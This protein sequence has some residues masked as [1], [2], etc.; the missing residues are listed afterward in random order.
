MHNG[1][2]K[3]LEDVVSFYDA[4]GGAGLGI[5]L[6]NQTLPPDSLHLSD[7][8]DTAGLVGGRTAHPISSGVTQASAR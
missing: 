3:T 6:P 8:T 4:G 7:L 5:E 1:A 2:L